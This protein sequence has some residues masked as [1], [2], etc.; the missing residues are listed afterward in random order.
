MV[1]NIYKWNLNVGETR[2]EMCKNAEILS[3]Q[4]Q[5]GS[6][7][8]WALI[9]ETSPLSERVFVVRTTGLPMTKDPG[10][11]VG[12]VQLDE[13]YFVAHVFETTSVE[14]ERYR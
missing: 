2:I 3:V 4:E 13:G 8:L 7:V 1:R 10:K 9:E 14:G 5:H 12:T 6:I 11:Y